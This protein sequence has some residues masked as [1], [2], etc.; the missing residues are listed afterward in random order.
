[1][2]NTGRHA[3][4]ALWYQR[5]AAAAAASH[6]GVD[7][8]GKTPWAA[9]SSG[10]GDST[11]IGSDGSGGAALGKAADEPSSGSEGGSEGAAGFL[12]AALE[13]STNSSRLDAKLA[14]R[15]LLCSL[16]PYVARV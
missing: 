16:F 13:G 15:A 7:A 9:N 4:T 8:G 1:M 3:D 10:A 12:A 2:V 11:S 6:D 5:V 14:V